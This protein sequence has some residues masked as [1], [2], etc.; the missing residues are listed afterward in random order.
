MNPTVTLVETMDELNAFWRWLGERRPILAIDTETTGLNWWEPGFLR[1]TQFG[2]GDNAW[3]IPQAWYGKAVKDAVENYT[4]PIV[5]QNIKFE[6]HAFESAGIKMPMGNLHDTQFLGWLSNPAERAGLKPLSIKHVD[7]RAG[8]PEYLKNR[9]FKTNKVS[10][11]T[12]PVDAM[13]YWFYGGWDPIITAR[14]WEKLQGYRGAAYDLEMALLPLVC[15]M[16]S[17]GMRVD[18]EYVSTTRS[19]WRTEMD[20]LLVALQQYGLANPNSGPQVEAAL[21]GEGWEPEEFTKTGRA[22]LDNGILLG[23][24]HEIGDLVIQYKRLSKWDSTYLRN[25]QKWDDNGVVHANIKQCEART[26]RM[27][28]VNPPLQTQPRGPIIRNCFIPGEGNQLLTVDYA[29]IELRLLAHF[30]QDATMI[31]QFRAGEDLHNMLAT[32]IYGSGFTSEQRSTAKNSWFAKAYG[33]KVETFA[34]SAGVPVEQAQA[35]Y[36]GLDE[37]YPGIRQFQDLCIETGK[38]RLREEGR[39]YI[40]LDDGTELPADDDA[41]YALVD[42]AL[43]GTAAKILKRASVSL[44]NAGFGDFMRMFVHDEVI[45]EIPTDLVAEVQ[46]EIEAIMTDAYTYAVPVLVEGTLCPGSWGSKY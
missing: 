26:G 10:W 33:A 14:L 4:G 24:P 38:T 7:P 18:H 11:D 15:R 5:G 12:V 19:A 36:D 27:A 41:Q 6:A 30:S 31:A 17:A 2:D 3:V 34:E 9:Y 32:A 8:F 25:L 45:F 46:P 29:Q 37:T 22:K 1:T 23:I 39:G 28:V 13:P 44:D 21:K 20:E 43:Q 16:E 35:I 40:R 42:F